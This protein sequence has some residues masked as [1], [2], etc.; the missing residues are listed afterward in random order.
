MH[1][2]SFESYLGKENMKLLKQEIELSIG[3]RLK[4]LLR[5][6]ININRLREQQQNGNKR[7]S[8]IV[9]TVKREIEAK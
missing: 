1:G 7:G 4:A 3:I 8:A 9:I 5:W 6:L 2:M